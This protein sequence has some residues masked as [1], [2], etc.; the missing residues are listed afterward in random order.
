MKG[1]SGM[2]TEPEQ[3]A[4]TREQYDRII[5]RSKKGGVKIITKY[6]K[7]LKNI[8]CEPIVLSEEK[9]KHCI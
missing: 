7:G 6:R 5:E 8:K 2:T 4:F 1:V 9:N 3:R